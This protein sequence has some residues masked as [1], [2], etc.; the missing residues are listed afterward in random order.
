MT[1]VAEFVRQHLEADA[2]LAVAALG[3]PDD[4]A[5]LEVQRRATSF[6]ATAT[7]PLGPTE[8]RWAVPGGQSPAA[9]VDV[10]DSVRPAALFAIGAAG[11][12]TW[13]VMVG[14]KRDPAGAALAEALLV[15]DTGDGLRIAGRA[16]VDPFSHGITF[17]SAGGEELDP[18]AAHDV[19]IVQEPGSPA[20]A[21][22]LSDWG[23]R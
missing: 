19:R 16:S 3:E 8:S 17:A 18:A 12:D 22:F 4:D 2:A 13:I 1:D 14:D 23:R 6:Y 20:H 10:S 5:Y 11:D 15:R 21:A 7:T 9:T